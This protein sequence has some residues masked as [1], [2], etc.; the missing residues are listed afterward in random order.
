MITLQHTALFALALAEK[1]RITGDHST[2]D[3]FAFEKEFHKEIPWL[4]LPDAI[5]Y[6][7]N[8]R[9]ASHFEQIPNDIED[10]ASWMEFPDEETLK[11]LSKENVNTK[12]FYYDDSFSGLSSKSVIGEETKLSR[13]DMCNWM[14]K[15]RVALRCH[16][17]QDILM[18]EC[19]RL[20]MVDVS[21][22]FENSFTI[23][24]NNQVIDGQTLRDQI[25][26]FEEI[27]FIRLVGA[28]YKKTG[29]LLN[30]EWFDKHVLESIKEAYPDDLATYTYKYMSIS[31][32]LNERINN[33]EFEFTSKEVHSFFLTSCLE[34][35]LD[36]LYGLALQETYAM[37]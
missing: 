34:A 13:F 14:N 35:T 19:L 33:H 16:L 24:Q 18:D 4:L 9:Q 29:M 28:I 1:R 17:I 6:Y 22:R 25:K 36:S 10:F 15:H 2:F 23:Y 11:N 12:V 8:S 5:R 20:D 21:N 27:G 7:I 32:E 31:D 30:R 37:L 26:I 3:F